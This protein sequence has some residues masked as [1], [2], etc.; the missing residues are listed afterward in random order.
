MTLA[1]RLVINED[2][3]NLGTFAP[4]IWPVHR[5]RAIMA[6]LDRLF[7][8]ADYMEVRN[9]VF[10]HPWLAPLLIEA[11]REVALH[12]PESAAA[13]SLQVV[14]DPEETQDNAQLVLWIRTDLPPESALA[15][16]RNLDVDW[17]LRVA[18]IAEGKLCLMLA[19]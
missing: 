12:F 2:Q 1:E 13:P 8:L 15:N 14:V 5:Y 9:F 18:S 16:L 17:W 3:G 6:T 19:P 11:A 10:L 4:N 7:V